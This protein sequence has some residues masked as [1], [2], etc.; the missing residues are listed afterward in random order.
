MSEKDFTVV[1]NNITIESNKRK[2]G[3]RTNVNVK[4]SVVVEDDVVV[5]GNSRAC[6][7]QTQNINP[8]ERNK[9]IVINVEILLQMINSDI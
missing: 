5:Q 9:D 8:C 2:C 4:G 6:D 3:S 7:L 1:G